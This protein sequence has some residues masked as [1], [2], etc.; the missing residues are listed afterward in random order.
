MHHKNPHIHLDPSS[1]LGFDESIR[2]RMFEFSWGSAIAP[3]PSAYL[4][5]LNKKVSIPFECKYHIVF[6]TLLVF[7]DA[8]ENLVM[9]DDVATLSN[10]SIS[11]VEKEELE[12][13]PFDM[14]VSQQS[15]EEKPS[16]RVVHTWVDHSAWDC[17]LF[18]NPHTLSIYLE[19]VLTCGAAPK[20]FEECQCEDD[21]VRLHCRTWVPGDGHYRWLRSPINPLSM[22]HWVEYLVRTIR[23]ILEFL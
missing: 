4:N 21:D 23:H 15:G 3:T 20:R 22:E 19:F 6:I 17:R 11:L 8:S 7:V 14:T 13:A 12:E 16:R 2:F 10:P 1:K 18:S 9:A 5:L